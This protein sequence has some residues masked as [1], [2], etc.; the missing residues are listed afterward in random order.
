MSYVLVGKDRY[1]FDVFVP[2]KASPTGKDVRIRT[3]QRCTP[4]QVR[5]L[6]A[7]IANAAVTVGEW[8]ASTS[9][10]L[11]GTDEAARNAD[12]LRLQ[13]QPSQSRTIKN[14]AQHRQTL[15]AALA[16]AWI[17]PDD[18][19][20]H[21]KTGMTQYRAARAALNILGAKIPC[22]SVTRADYETIRDK[23]R[24]QGRSEAIVTRHLQALFRVLFFAQREGWIK[25]R[26]R[27][28]RRRA[29]SRMFTYSPEV[30]AQC[31]AFFQST[32]GSGPFPNG[33][34]EVFIAGIDA[35]LR[36]GEVLALTGD[37][38]DAA[39]RIVHVRDERNKSERRQVRISERLA[40]I[41]ARRVAERGQWLLFGEWAQRTV[42]ARM[43]A[44]REHL[45]PDNE[46]F[47]FQSARHTHLLR[48][49]GDED[50]SAILMEQ[51]GHTSPHIV[52]R[53]TRAALAER[54]RVAR[55]ERASLAR[56]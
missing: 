7:E 20:A 2:S 21:T 19:W 40:G 43:L 45:D 54:F 1:L 56:A 12:A 6:D 53:Y 22:A 39:K 5:A 23:L 46:D 48:L 50:G 13:R 3:R 36:L 11:R 16:L 27:F 26:P 44:A 4:D 17:S 28:H 24:A 37:G 38:V 25:A 10:I 41:L 42:M 18:G 55:E 52:A 30:E 15:E 14:T 33:M 9:A 51:A 32:E 8:S 35:G 49:A 47:T 34:H 31:I 29:L